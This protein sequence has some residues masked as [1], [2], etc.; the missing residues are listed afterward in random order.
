MAAGG[1]PRRDHAQALRLR[2]DG[3]GR[4]GADHLDPRG[5]RSG[6]N[7]DYRFCWLRDAYFVVHALNRLGATKTMEDYLGFIADVVDDTIGAGA[8]HLPPL[9]AIARSGDLEERMAEALTGYRGD[10]PVRYGN[11]AHDQI[12]DD[13]YGAV[14]LAAAQA[15]FDARMIRPGNEALFRQLEALGEIAVA[16]FGQPDAGPWELR[17]FAQVHTF[18]SVMCWA[19]CDRLA[20]IAEAAFGLADRA[21][22]WRAEARRMRE[23]ILKEAWSEAR[24]SFVAS[25]GGSDLDASLLLL[26]GLGFIEPSDPRFVATVEAV[27]K[28]LVRG[29][30][31]LRYDSRDDFGRMESGFLI[32]SFWYIDA[33]HAIGRKDEAR[34]LFDQVLARR[35]SFGLLS[36][37]ADLKTG[38]LWGNFP[39]PT[40]MSA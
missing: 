29:D 24:G 12:Q 6:R 13:G 22:R 5:A 35:N 37:D 14:I 21:A 11:G 32:C 7:W 19:A 20:L 4:R 38:E 9:H 16:R 27:G 26:P 40:P 15:F 25:F 2:G 31:V 1:D 34:A 36:E 28:A 10:R 33:L 23:A 17:T 30:L 8:E 39:R 3:R 18:S